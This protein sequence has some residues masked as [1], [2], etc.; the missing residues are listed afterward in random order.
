MLWLGIETSCDDTG[1]ALVEDGRKIHSSVMKSQ[2]VHHK[3]YGGVAPEIASRVHLDHFLPTL[4][5]ALQMA[6]KQLSDIDGIAVTE[7]P[8]LMGS[9]LIGVEAGR[10][11]GYLCDVPVLGINHLQA[12]FYSIYLHHCNSLKPSMQHSKMTGDKGDFTHHTHKESVNDRRKESSCDEQK[13]EDYDR[14]NFPKKNQ[15]KN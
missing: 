5:E 13:L 7:K 3:K 4:D 8:G 11:L 15:K 6:N 2:H 1:I 9:L 12:H 14:D 10:T